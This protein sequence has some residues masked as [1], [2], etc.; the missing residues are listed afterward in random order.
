MCSASAPD[1]EAHDRTAITSLTLARA[2]Q[3]LGRALALKNSPA[4]Y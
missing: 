2:A 1:D 4:T 3:I